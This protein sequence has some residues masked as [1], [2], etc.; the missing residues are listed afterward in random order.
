MADQNKALDKEST[1]F[2]CAPIYTNYVQLK[3]STLLL[4]SQKKMMGW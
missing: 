3:T 1:M 4:F 2:G